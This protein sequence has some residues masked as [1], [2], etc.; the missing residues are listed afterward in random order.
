MKRRS[1]PNLSNRK[2]QPSHLT[3]FVD[4]CVG[5]EI[6]PEALRKAG[7][8]V[9]IHADHLAQGVDDVDVLAFCGHHGW[10][11]L[12]KDVNISRNPAERAALVGAKI[13]AVFYSKRQAT[14][15]EMAAAL[16]PAMNRLMRRFVQSNKPVHVVVR[17]SGIIDTLKL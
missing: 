4:E 5:S 2:S 12:S 11:F 1:A 14:G 3:I 17:P 13:H 16:V 7:H 10:I 8:A 15:S 9:E 6:V